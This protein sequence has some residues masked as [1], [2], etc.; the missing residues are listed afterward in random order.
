MKRLANKA[1]SSAGLV[2]VLLNQVLQIFFGLDNIRAL[3]ISYQLDEPA[4]VNSAYRSRM[5]T[6]AVSHSLKGTG[7]E[8]HS[9]FLCVL[10][11]VSVLHIA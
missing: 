10:C 2:E 9:V 5:I 8:L 6:E 3:S 1:R 11:Q 7:W 4:D